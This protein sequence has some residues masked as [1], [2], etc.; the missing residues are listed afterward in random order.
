[1]PFIHVLGDTLVIVSGG[2]K[3]E[4]RLKCSCGSEWVIFTDNTKERE[5]FIKE[6]YKKHKRC[7]CIVSAKTHAIEEK[8]T[9][10]GRKNA[11]KGIDR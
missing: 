1:L 10:R 4:H 5:R 6:F 11:T 9:R 2:G 3:L 8:Q 7:E